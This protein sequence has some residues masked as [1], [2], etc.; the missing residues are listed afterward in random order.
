MPKTT[1]E[2]VIEI[3]TG[4]ETP[5]TFWQ[6]MLYVKQEL[7]KFQKSAINPHFKSKYIPLDDINPAID[8]ILT[9]HGFVWVTKPTITPSGEAGLEYKMVYVIDGTQDVGVMKLENDKSGPQGQGSGITYARRYALCA[10][11][12]IVADADDDGEKAEGAQVE[13]LKQN[14]LKAA[15]GLSLDEDGLYARTGVKLETM[16]KKQL[17]QTL[18]QL[19]TALTAQANKRATSNE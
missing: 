12:G 7:P 6:A 1:P 16:D 11:L 18:A 3:N 15:A 19:T 17:D 5:L 4:E 13:K 10:Y 14:I 9:V 2:E 8:E